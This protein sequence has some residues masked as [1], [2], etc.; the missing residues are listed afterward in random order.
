MIDL[1]DPELRK[2]ASNLP[3]ECDLPNGL[4][5]AARLVREWQIHVDGLMPGAYVSLVLAAGD[6]VM[7]VPLCEEE[8]GSGYH[9]QLAFAGRGGVEVI[10]QDSS[11][12]ST[13]MPRLRPGTMLHE[14]GLTPLQ[15]VEVCCDLIRRLD[16]APIP[17]TPPI[18]A[19]YEA[20][21]RVESAEAIPDKLLRDAQTLASRLLQTTTD[22]KLL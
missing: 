16:I 22:R 4:R 18:E 10:R 19:W 1:N 14:E 7:R 17:E 5:T 11:S 15:E 3:P 2:L 21:L 8:S 9:A 13:L 20:F 6:Y 12:G